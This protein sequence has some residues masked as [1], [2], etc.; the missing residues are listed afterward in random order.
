MAKEISNNISLHNGLLT[1]NTKPLSEPMLFF[2]ASSSDN[3]MRAIS[4]DQ[5]ANE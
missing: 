1:D 4:R 5:E 3:N 2:S